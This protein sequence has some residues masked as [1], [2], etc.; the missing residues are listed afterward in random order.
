MARALAHGFLRAGLAE[1][2]QL[3]VLDVSPEAAKAFADLC[4]D[5]ATIAED[6]ADL[7]RRSTLLIL[8]VKPQHAAEALQRLAP[9]VDRQ[10]LLVSIVAGLTLSRLRT[11]APGARLV[12]VMP[13]TPCLVGQGATAFALGDGATDEDEG[14]VQRL[15]DAVGLARRVDESLLDAV[16]GLSGSGP[17]FVYLAIEALADGGVQAGLPRALAAELAA[18][19]VLGAAQM[20]RETGEHPGVLKD[21][22]AS[23]AGTTIAGLQSLER[24][25]F[26]AALIDAVEAAAERSAELGRDSTSPDQN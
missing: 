13:N 26:R 9:H 7:S 19:T 18:Q 10:T 16:T 4:G 11:A 22:V 25:G 21:R 2:S 14:L 1:A 6:A 8:A 15:L 3:S 23:P 12:R 20:V 5:G 24:A 17:A